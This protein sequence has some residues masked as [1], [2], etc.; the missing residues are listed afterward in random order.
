MYDPQTGGGLAMA[1]PYNIVDVNRKWPRVRVH[2]QGSH[3]CDPQTGG[4]PR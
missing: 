3:M 1:S 4:A 2:T